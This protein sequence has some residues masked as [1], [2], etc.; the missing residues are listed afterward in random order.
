MKPP[1]DTVSK[2]ITSTLMSRVIEGVYPAGSKLPTEREIAEEFKVT[3]NVVREALKR[4]EALGLLKI[5]QG[6]G[7][8]VEDLRTT[9]GVELLDLLIIKEDGSINLEMLRDIIEYYQNTIISVMQLAAR[10]ITDDEHVEFQRLA[11]E[12]SQAIG[13]KERLAEVTQEIVA[14]I[15]DATHNSFYRLLYNTMMRI[16]IL[17]VGFTNIMLYLTPDIQTYFERMAEAFERKDHEMAGLLTIRMFESFEGDAQNILKQISQY[18][19][20]R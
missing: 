7:I 2:L 14:F 10:R 1:V 20:Y 8:Y 3:R 15:V 19:I 16:P 13:D 4:L 12:R 17:S 6:S 9:G 11:A 5:R 18:D